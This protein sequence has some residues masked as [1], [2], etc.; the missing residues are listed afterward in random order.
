M[1]NNQNYNVYGIEYSVKKCLKSTKDGN[2]FYNVIDDNSIVPCLVSDK[3]KVYGPVLG[4]GMNGKISFRS[5]MGGDI[6]TLS[7]KKCVKFTGKNGSTFYKVVEGQPVVKC[8]VNNKNNRVVG[9]VKD[10]SSYSKQL[11]LILSKE[12]ERK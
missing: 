10:G 1:Q 6:Q 4:T 7:I 12:K 3:G 2:I 8:F 11:L 5:T 9:E